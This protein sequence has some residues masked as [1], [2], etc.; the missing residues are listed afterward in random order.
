MVR[1]GVFPVFAAL[2]FLGACATAT[3]YQAASDSS[4]GYE[5]QQIESNRWQVSFAGNSLTDRETVETYLLYRAAE[6]TRQQG[7]DHFRVVR[8][9]TDA[10][11]RFVATGF[12]RSFSSFNSRFY[13]NYRFFGSRSLAFSRSRFSRFHDPFGHGFGAPDFREIVR[14]E[15][16]AEIVMGSGPKPE[17]DPAFFDAGQVL[18]NLSG[19][20]VRP[21]ADA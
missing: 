7:F 8:R 12:S 21:E 18:D 11:S 15:A 1:I 20:I 14:Y 19:E 13:Y 4:R 17:S 2:V 3:P 6:L 16:T 9:D 10:N 5:N